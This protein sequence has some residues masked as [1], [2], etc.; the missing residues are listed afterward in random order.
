MGM[1]K[2]VY[3]DAWYAGGF[4]SSLHIVPDKTLGECE[5]PVFRLNTI[6]FLSVALQLL[7]DSRRHGS[8][9]DKPQKSGYSAYAII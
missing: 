7:H 9:V 4:R 2:V 8:V 6:T 5:Y 3:P 1:A